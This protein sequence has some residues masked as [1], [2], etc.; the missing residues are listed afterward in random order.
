MA[1][2]LTTTSFFTLS[3]R[4]AQSEQAQGYQAYNVTVE[5]YT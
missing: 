3:M 2:C 4:H 1:Y 5:P